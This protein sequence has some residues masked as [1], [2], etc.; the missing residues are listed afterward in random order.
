MENDLCSKGY[1]YP[2]LHVKIFL[3]GGGTMEGIFLNVAFFTKQIFGIPR[4]HIE[5]E[6]V[7]NLVK[8]LTTL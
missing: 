7:F 4:S 5:M 8:V 6:N 1:P 2:L 3:L